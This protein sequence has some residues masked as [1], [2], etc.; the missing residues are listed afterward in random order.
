MARVTSRPSTGDPKSRP[1]SFRRAIEKAEA[2]GVGRADM[3]LRLTLSDTAALKRDRGIPVED[4]CFI[5][6]V[7]SF[8]GVTVTT[9]GVSVSA[10]QTEADEEAAAV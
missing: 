8:M 9:G 5:D 10:L 6:G 4:I 1:D 3:V 7:M 2:E